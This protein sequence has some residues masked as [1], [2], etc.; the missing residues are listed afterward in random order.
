MT[1]T[2]YF[3]VGY[4]FTGSWDDYF[5]LLVLAVAAGLGVLLYIER[6]KHAPD[7][8]SPPM[9]GLRAS[10]YFCGVL[11]VSW[12]SGVFKTVV[13]MPLT[14]PQQL[15][16]PV[17]VSFAV[18]CFAIVI[19]AYGYWW[20]RGTLTHGRKL[21]FV[22]TALYGLIW[23]ACAGLLFLTIYAILEHFQ[24][25]RL[26]NAILLV[27][28]LSVYNMNY[29]L[30][31]WD[32]HVSPPHNIKATNVGKV[33]LSH[34]PFLISSL[35]FFVIYGNAGIYVILNACAL[36]ASAVALRFPPFWA[37]DGGPVSTDTAIGE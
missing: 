13:Q 8:H 16:D 20:P 2:N 25:P 18:L 17:W 36:G 31:W 15:A 28:L 32:I 26:V 9:A 12:V 21:Y 19:W 33:L 34:N 4:V 1:P 5:I 7:H 35:A 14:T 29:Q 3:T 22:P 23:G 30:G 27:M 10:L 6:P 37:E 11:T 24:F